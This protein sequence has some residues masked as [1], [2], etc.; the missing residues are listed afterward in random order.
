MKQF[1]INEKIHLTIGILILLNEEEE[2]KAVDLVKEWI[3]ET[4]LVV[5]VIS[6][7][8]TVLKTLN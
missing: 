5:A 1:Q 6:E 2:N 3:R 7:L 8:L 4:K